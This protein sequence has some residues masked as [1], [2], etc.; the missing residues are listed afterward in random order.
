MSDE[1]LICDEYAARVAECR[2][3]DGA[4]HML[5]WCFD[6]EIS[7]SILSATAQGRLERM[8]DLFGVSMFFDRIIGQ[9]D[10]YAIGKIEKGKK[11]LTELNLDSSEVLLIGDTTHDAQV[12]EGVCVDYFLVSVGHHPRSKLER[13]SS[14]VFGNLSEVIHILENMRGVHA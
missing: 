10:H 13:I 5:K 14:R 11:L 4:L 2:L 12:A 3:Q 1:Q 6:N 7:Q 8:V 9:T